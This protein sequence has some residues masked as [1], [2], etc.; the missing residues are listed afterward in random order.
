[1]NTW[2]NILERAGAWMGTGDRANA[3]SNLRFFR[4]SPL[5][6]PCMQIGS[7]LH[8]AAP[9]SAC[10]HWSETFENGMDAQTSTGSPTNR[11]HNSTTAFT[12]FFKEIMPMLMLFKNTLSMLA[13]LTGVR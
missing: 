6:S 5:P 7:G 3:T 8:Y 11:K 12:L 1:M 9:L 4:A 2:E 13:I 10:S